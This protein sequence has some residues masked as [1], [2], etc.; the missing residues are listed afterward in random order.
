[1]RVQG[2]VGMTASNKSDRDTVLLRLG[3]YILVMNFRGWILYLLFNHLEN[4]F[5]V[6]PENGDCWYEHLLKSHQ[7]G[8]YG[9]DFDFSDHAVLFFSQILPIALMEVL[10]CLVVPYWEVSSSALRPWFSRAVPFTLILCLLH[11]Y[12]ISLINVRKTA[13]YFHTGPEILL[14]YAMSLIVQLPLAFLQCF[15]FWEKARQVIFGY[16]SSRLRHS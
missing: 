13:E 10:H 1:M 4:T 9:H 5:F 3:F 16:P 7:P 6:S 11:L 14:G 15:P 2:V 12:L 8:C